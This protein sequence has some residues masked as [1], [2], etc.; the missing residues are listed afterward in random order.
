MNAYVEAEEIRQKS[1]RWFAHY[2][3][4]GEVT[5][6]ELLTVIKVDD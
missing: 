3:A 4:T 6:A 2:V 1:E 5:G